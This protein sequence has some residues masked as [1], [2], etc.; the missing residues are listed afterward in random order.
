MLL[1]YLC[2]YSPYAYLLDL[3]NF[4]ETPDV[5]IQCSK[6]VNEHFCEIF[7]NSVAKPGRDTTS[8]LLNKIDL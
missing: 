2:P 3:P 7:C 6:M 4:L 8:K 1:K 5:L